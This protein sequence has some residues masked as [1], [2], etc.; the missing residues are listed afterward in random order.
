ML[1]NNYKSIQLNLNKQKHK[2]LI[3][4]IKYM[5]DVEERSINSFIINIL[6]KENKKYVEEKGKED[7]QQV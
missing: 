2:D 7:K 1:K 3:E 6:K 4:W 5:C